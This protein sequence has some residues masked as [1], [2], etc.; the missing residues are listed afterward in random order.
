M[1]DTGRR[2]LEKKATT[3]PVWE[4]GYSQG[5]Q[6]QKIKMGWAHSEEKRGGNH[7]NNL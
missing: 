1:S 5:G 7:Q 6:R 2:R 3:E 4:A